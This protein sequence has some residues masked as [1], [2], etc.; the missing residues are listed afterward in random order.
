MGTAN[1]SNKN[2][3]GLPSK[4]AP[5]AKKGAPISE[6]RPKKVNYIF[7][8]TGIVLILL[9]AIILTR[10]K[11]SRIGY[12][13]LTIGTI[14]ALSQIPVILDIKMANGISAG[15]A[16]ALGAM[17]YFFAPAN[18]ITNA[19]ISTADSTDAGRNLPDCNN[20]K[21]SVAVFSGGNLDYT[22]AIKTFFL[23]SLQPKMNFLLNRCLYYEDYYVTSSLN[24]S[25]LQAQFRNTGFS[26]RA[27][28]YYV[29]IGTSAAVGL[30]K[31][32]EVN[33]LKNRRIIFLGITDP[34]RSGLVSSFTNRNETSNIAGVAY[35]GNFERLPL[36][37]KEFYPE[38]TLV[39]IY[40]NENLQDVQIANGLK[41]IPM[42]HN[43]ELIIKELN[44]KDPTINDFVD[45]SKVY[46][47]WLTLE[48]FFSTENV[49][50]IRQIKK[51]VSTTQT[52]AELGLIPLAVSSSDEEIG[53][54]GADLLIQSL[55]NPKQNLGTFSVV[56]PEW[57]SYVN[58]TLARNHL[59]VDAIKT[60]DK[61]F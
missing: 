20:E 41:G 11:G 17:L 43:G 55:R 30:K 16:A 42:E 26:R 44:H 2:P 9:S 36:K 52:H 58:Q 38:D 7:F 37:I 51:V 5:A 22:R 54:A 18:G 25:L 57:K 31:Y 50:I 49:S 34:I 35:C 14:L 45:S 39:Y 19:F 12:A 59:N 24:D 1:T 60:A 61:K 8:C 47:S 6:E 46:F 32:L 4:K 21:I 29:V 3:S 33:G 28:D 15:G 40:N 48:N 53:K 10:D 13:I 23:N 27:F 56:V